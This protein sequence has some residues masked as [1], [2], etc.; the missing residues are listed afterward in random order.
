LIDTDMMTEGVRSLLFGL[1]Y[2]AESDELAD[3]PRRLAEA[4]AELTAGEQ[5]DP[6]RF[7]KVTFAA[8]ADE[9]IVLRRCPLTSVCEHH[10][11]PFRGHATVGYIPAPGAGVVGLSK[12]ARVVDGYARRLQ[13]QER[14]TAQIAGCIEAGLSTAG[15]AVTIT[16][17]HECL[18]VRGARKDGAELVTSDTRGAFRA[19][20][21]ARA[22]FFALA[23]GG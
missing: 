8:D 21:A 17:V 20:P 15:V 7:L 1:G 12:L 18:S 9:M 13:L 3:T 6:A 5:V 16:A 11:M 23:R 22:E 4:L 14:L 2:D 10:L 19:D